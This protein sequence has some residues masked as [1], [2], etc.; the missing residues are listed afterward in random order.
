[1][2]VYTNANPAA[3][4]T[5]IES[6]PLP[7]GN[8]T[9]FHC[10]GADS[11][12]VRQWLTSPE[13]GQEIVAETQVGG[14]PVLVT[15]GDKSGDALLKL[16]EKPGESFALKEPEKQFN[17]WKWRGTFSN[18][19][20]SLNLISAY[21][22]PGGIDIP[23]L[24]FS[25]L[26][27]AASF[28]NSTFGSQKSQDEFQLRHLKQ[29]VNH[30]LGKHLPEDCTPPDINDERHKLRQDPQSPKTIGQKCSDMMKANS[31]RIG[32]IGLRYMGSIAMTFP[33]KNWGPALAQWRNGS[34]AGAFATAR[35]KD[36]TN[37]FT[38]LTYLMGKTVGLFSK[39]P[40]PYNPAPHTALDTVREK[41]LFR[42]SSLIET[43]AATT[44]AIGNFKADK[45]GKRDF[46]GAAGGVSLMAGLTT[47]LFAKF[48]SREVDMDEL[49]AHATDILAMEPPAQ[50]PQLLADAAAAI[51]E[52][53][54]DKAT[55]EYGDIYVRMM[56]DLYHYHHIAL[57][58]L[59]T[60]P[61]E[62]LAKMPAPSGYADSVGPK[63]SSSYVDM[64]KTPSGRVSLE[65]GT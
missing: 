29:S 2:A 36:S 57:D 33:I 49:Y 58:N 6:V 12:A 3:A 13:A 47:R 56:N 52:H 30:L 41:Y 40:D 45:N 38:G 14:K 59:G 22:K 7:D 11:T 37:F 21:R 16:L 9:F 42:L 63:R 25:G 31:V 62:R 61:D 46:I 4:I 39:V 20:Q 55:L 10:G 44:L 1:M 23:K 24:T 5:T 28:V 26:N 43:G 50:L 34:L 48:G 60:E 35:N 27:F 19:G 8:F 17:A 18:V 53:F 15:H 51:K 64:V 54:K 32:E 65:L